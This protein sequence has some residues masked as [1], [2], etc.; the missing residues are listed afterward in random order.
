MLDDA[1]YRVNI[2]RERAA[3]GLWSWSKIY[4]D[5]LLLLLYYVLGQ[6]D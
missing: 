3:L 6:G 5:V 2:S 4:I 1:E